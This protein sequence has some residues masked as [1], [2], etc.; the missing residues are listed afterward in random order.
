MYFEAIELAPW[1]IGS[2]N[3]FIN[4]SMES[5]IGTE[6]HITQDNTNADNKSI[7]IDE[8]KTDNQIK[9]FKA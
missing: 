9:L 2:N 3:N 1:E 8:K 7:K 6:K 5:L 4:D